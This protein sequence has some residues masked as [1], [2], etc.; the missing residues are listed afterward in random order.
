[1]WRILYDA[2][3]PVT[4]VRSLSKEAR[5]N[6]GKFYEATASVMSTGVETPRG[7]ERNHADQNPDQ[8]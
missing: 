8:S 7:A 1:M 5:I 3:C 4:D 2:G 6:Q